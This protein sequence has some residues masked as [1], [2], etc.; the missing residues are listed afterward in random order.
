MLLTIVS[1]I[2]LGKNNSNNQPEKLGENKDLLEEKYTGIVNC[3]K[4]IP[5]DNEYYKVYE[6]QEIQVN[7]GIVKERNSLFKII[8]NSKYNY[9]GFK[10]NE[11]LENPIYDDENLTIIY[12][13]E[14]KIDMSYDEYEYREFIKE[15]EDNKGYICKE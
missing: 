10:V 7:K 4:E 12:D 6:I 11:K 13:N 15:L 1:L 8:Y 9:E 2:I 5:T 3:T 14:G